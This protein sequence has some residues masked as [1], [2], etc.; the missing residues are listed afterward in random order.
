MTPLDLKTDLS[1]KD[2]IKLIKPLLSGKDEEARFNTTH[3]R[4]DGSKYPVEVYLQVSDYKGQKVFIANIL[5]ITEQ[6]EYERK[7]EKNLEQVS[8]KNRYHEIIST[9]TG[10]VHSLSRPSGS[11]G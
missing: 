11:Y 8:K 4:K 10:S 6:K 7:L 3:R 2:F 9:V 5:D 1:E